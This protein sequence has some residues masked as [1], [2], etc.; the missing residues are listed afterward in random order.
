VH[1]A[2]RDSCQLPHPCIRSRVDNSASLFAGVGGQIDFMRGSSLSTD[3]LGKPILAMAST[4]KGGLSK[5]VPNLKTGEEAF[6]PYASSL[7]ASNEKAFT[8]VFFRGGGLGF[9]CDYRL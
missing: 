9:I 7:L 1:F 6:Y 4:T 2:L 8:P 3:G 5:I